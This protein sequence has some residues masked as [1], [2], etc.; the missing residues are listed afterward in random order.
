MIRGWDRAQSV[1]RHARP[2][3]HSSH[4]QHKLVHTK[5]TPQQHRLTDNKKVR[6]IFVGVLKRIR[7]IFRSQNTQKL[8]LFDTVRLLG[9]CWYPVTVTLQEGV[10]LNQGLIEFF[11]DH[12]LPIAQ[13]AH[14][15]RI[16]NGATSSAS[17]RVSRTRASSERGGTPK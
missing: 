4:K 1:S 16:F 17:S 14:E 15:K 10:R 8:R 6:L 7:F 11:V 5:S 13:S 3:A 9:F 2:P 12:C